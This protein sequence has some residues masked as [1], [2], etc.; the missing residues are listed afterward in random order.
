M[1]LMK[2][3][4]LLS[5]LTAATLILASTAAQAEMVLHRG[6]GAEPETMDPQKSTG[7]TEANIQYEIFEGLTTYSPDG[8]V[9]PGMAEKWDVSDD[10]KT[11]TFHLRDAKWSNGDPVTAEDFVYSFQRLVDPAIAADYAPIADPILNAEQIRKGEEKDLTKLGVKAVD[12]K[13]FEVTLARPAPYF[14]GLIR[15]NTFLPVHKATVEKFGQDWTK[16]GNMV[17]N[18]AFTMES[19]TPQASMA[20][21]K[22]PSYYDAANVKLDKIVYYPTEDIS[23]EF[24]RYRA[25]ELHITYEVPSD[26][27]KFIEANMKDE[28]EAKP[29]LGTYYYVVNGTR[30]AGSKKEVREALALAIDREAIAEKVTGGSFLP[31]YSWVP[32]GMI[33]YKTQYV[34]FKDMPKQQRIAKAKELLAAAG[35]GP[36]N[37]L[38][39]EILYNTSENHK[40][41]AIAV[42]SMWKAIGVNATL[43]NQEWQVYLDTRDEKQF[44]VARAGW[45][46]DFADPVTFLDLFLSDAGVRNDAGYNNPEY[47]KLVKNS[48]GIGDPETR[49]ASLQRAEQ[50]FLNDLPIIPILTYKTKH[51][52]SK[53]V[54]GWAYNNLDFHLGRY[55]SVQ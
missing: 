16:P 33:G 5:A 13:T 22:S 15:H 34:S 55:M 50:I 2:R 28:Y 53:K 27:I 36:D 3:N 21:A 6:N 39:M 25:G 26:Q 29:Y 7:V 48:F 35:Y 14:L 11:Y 47:D 31:G 4:V 44:D 32:P 12:A 42:Q 19:W 46:G 45:I 23:E 49:L 8:E 41:I 30:E 52:V 43:N 1:S 18:G 24:K 9:V 10:G 38:N 17:G 54:Q 37:P 20:L 51:M 40:K